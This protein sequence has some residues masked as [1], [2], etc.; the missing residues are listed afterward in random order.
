MRDSADVVETSEIMACQQLN[1]GNP[2]IQSGPK[3]HLIGAHNSTSRGEKLRQTHLFL[4]IYRGPITPFISIVGAYFVAQKKPAPFMNW[5]FPTFSFGG[6]GKILLDSR[7][8]QLPK[9]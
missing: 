8:S 3:N 2:K 9:K 4:A 7:P 5:T 6:G 1:L